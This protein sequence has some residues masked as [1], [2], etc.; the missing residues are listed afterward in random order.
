ML[1]ARVAHPGLVIP[2]AVVA[3]LYGSLYSLHGNLNC[4]GSGGAVGAAAAQL[5]CRRE[6]SVA[7]DTVW[8]LV[9]SQR[10]ELFFNYF[11]TTYICARYKKS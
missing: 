9:C 1:S 3:P 5:D 8:A 7:D 6:F 11:F 2:V 4:P 10:K